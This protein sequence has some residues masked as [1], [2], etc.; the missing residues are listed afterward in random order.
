MKSDGRGDGRR[1]GGNRRRNDRRGFGLGFEQLALRFSATMTE[2]SVFRKRRAASTTLWHASSVPWLGHNPPEELLYSEE[3][4]ALEAY[5][6]TTKGGG[7]NFGRLVETCEAFGPYCLIGGLAVNC[8]VEPVYTL[9]A[10]IVAAASNLQSLAQRLRQEGYKIESQPHSLNATLPE[11][12]LRIQFTT[13]ERYQ[14]FL[15]RALTAE[16]LGVQVKIACLDD[17][18]R[19]KLWAYSDPK[20]R[21]SKRKKDELDLIRLAEAYPHL[22]SGYPPEIVTQLDQG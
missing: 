4:N 11:S 19:G 8:Y 22:K 9:D 2:E 12:E 3:V 5:D 13:D 16:V 14:E 17:I 15:P 6:L 10:D 1:R 18:V 21:L 20:R 7:T